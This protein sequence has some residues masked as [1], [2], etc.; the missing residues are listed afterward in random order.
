VIIWFG[1]IAKRLIFVNEETT[2]FTGLPAE[3][4]LGQGWEQVIHPDDLESV[5]ATY[6]GSVDRR[7]SYQVEY[8]ARRADGEYR[9]MLAT[10]NPR[11]V[12]G[13]Y[14]GWI[15]SVIDITDLK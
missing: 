7:A 11:Y 15:G 4:L 1:D 3:Q 5:R 8:R 14:T 2:R 6:S 13:E 9:N 10:T 12:A